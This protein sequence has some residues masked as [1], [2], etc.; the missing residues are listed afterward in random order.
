L[1]HDKLKF[2]SSYVE[3]DEVKLMLES[4]E[5]F[6]FLKDITHIVRENKRDENIEKK[7][8]MKNLT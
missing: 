3:S 8:E 4:G 1:T 5:E 6:Q 7:E 2:P